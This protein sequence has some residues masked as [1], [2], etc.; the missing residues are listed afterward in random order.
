V[1]PLVVD[2]RADRIGWKQNRKSHFETVFTSIT[3]AR[4]QTNLYILRNLRRLG[5]FL[6]EITPAQEPAMLQSGWTSAMPIIPTPA[7]NASTKPTGS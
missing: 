4:Y 2:V 1:F 6:I 3:P 5:R 7:L